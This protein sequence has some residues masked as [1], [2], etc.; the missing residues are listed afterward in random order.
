MGAP[1]RKDDHDFMTPEEIAGFLRGTATGYKN[2]GRR[3][4]VSEIKDMLLKA[5]PTVLDA[6]GGTAINWETFK[7]M[8][9]PVRYT[10]MDRTT[11][12]TEFAADKYGNEIN[13]VDGHVQKMPLKDATF[14]VVIL[15]HIM[16][17]LPPGDMEKA[18]SEALR[19]A[20]HSVLISFFLPPDDRPEH[21]IRE[22]PSN[23]GRDGCTHFWNHYSHRRLMEYLTSFGF[24]VERSGSII[25][26]GAAHY[27]VVY[28][29]T[30]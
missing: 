7:D 11:K 12:M 4:L 28:R 6:A 30:K 15:R 26:M 9:Y 8:N 10:L 2:N 3:Y 22:N 1:G 23:N 24:Q 20:R 16:E 27:D 19:V 25:T 21:D 5:P 17:H 13:I 14:D 18:I 29:I